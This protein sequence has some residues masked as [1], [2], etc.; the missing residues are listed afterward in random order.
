[1]HF[2]LG[3]QILALIYLGKLEYQA[4]FWGNWINSFW[5][6]RYLGNFL[7]GYWDIAIPYASLIG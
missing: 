5:D 4:L 1:M 6:M 2:I 7:L 3:Y